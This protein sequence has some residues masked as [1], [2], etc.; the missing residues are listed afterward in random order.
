MKSTETI[1]AINVIY[2]ETAKKY[3]VM[4]FMQLPVNAH[5]EKSNNSCETKLNIHAI[6][7]QSIRKFLI[8]KLVSP[9]HHILALITPLEQYKQ[10]SPQLTLVV[11]AEEKTDS[12]P[13]RNNSNRGEII[14]LT[15]THKN[16]TGIWNNHHQKT[17]CTLEYPKSH[18]FRRGAG[19]PSN[20]VFSSFK[21]R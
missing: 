14:R 10:E 15:N 19:L 5:K 2:H 4:I 7:G 21:S 17:R 20:N 8:Q 9:C 13:V 3:H 18:I 11:S 16:I 12:N 6:S 1:R